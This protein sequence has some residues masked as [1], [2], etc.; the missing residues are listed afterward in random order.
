MGEEMASDLKKFKLSPKHFGKVQ[1][2]Y[3]C[4][5]EMLEEH[6]QENNV[7]DEGDLM[8]KSEEDS[9]NE[10]GAIVVHTIETGKGFLRVVEW[11]EEIYCLKSDVV[12]LSPINQMTKS[13][14]TE[15]TSRETCAAW[16]R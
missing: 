11:K 16:N 3:N 5:K 4:L 2:M 15:I 10:Y 9:L 7:L 12:A 6:K 8:Q 14:N 1:K 13:W